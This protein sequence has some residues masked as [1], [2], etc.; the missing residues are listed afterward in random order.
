M[1]NYGQQKFDGECSEDR[2]GERKE[3]LPERKVTPDIN[4]PTLTIIVTTSH[5]STP[6]T[7]TTAATPFTTT[8]DGGSVLTCPQCDRTFTSRISLFGHL[9]IHLIE[10]GE[11][12]PRAL[13]H[14]RNRRLHC[15]YCA[16]ALTHR[17][18]LFGHMR[19]HDSGIHGHV[20]NTDTPC[21]PS[22][23]AILNATATP[24]GVIGP[25]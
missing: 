23:P 6:V 3:T 1:S 11:R 14:S 8:S 5:Y 21:T 18:G 9:R 10:T 19:M 7:S 12:V 17:M 15:P 13:T 25:Y 2:A 16:R 4:S 22:V 24:T 20:D